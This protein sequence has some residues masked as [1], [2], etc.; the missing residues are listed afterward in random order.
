MLIAGLQQ[1][2]R[3][4][5]AFVKALKERGYFKSFNSEA[6]AYYVAPLINSAGRLSDASLASEFLFTKDIDEARALF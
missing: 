4:N 6:I 2:E 1:L 3:G 5:Y